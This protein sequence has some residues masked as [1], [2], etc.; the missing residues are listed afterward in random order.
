MMEHL[1]MWIGYLALIA[2]PYLSIFAYLVWLRKEL[3]KR[4]D[5]W[6]EILDEVG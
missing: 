2:F 4:W 6:F 3:P 1:L 5:A